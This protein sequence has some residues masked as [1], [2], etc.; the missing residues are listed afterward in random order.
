[1]ASGTITKQTE[2]LVEESNVTFANGIYKLSAKSGYTLV[3]TY[4]V[5]RSDSERN[6]YALVSIQRNTDGSYNLL[7][8]NTTLSAGIRLLRVWLRTA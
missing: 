1:M 3:N 6:S 7:N 5:N 4:I 2:I 8:N